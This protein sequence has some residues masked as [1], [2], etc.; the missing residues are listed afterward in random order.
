MFFLGT[1]NVC[2]NNFAQNRGFVTY[3]I[4][5]RRGIN[6]REGALWD[7]NPSKHVQNS[8]FMGKEER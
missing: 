5:R 8:I 6:E 7:L 2:G 3:V 1:D 4:R